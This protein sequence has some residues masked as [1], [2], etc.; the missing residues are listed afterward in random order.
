M[1]DH[2]KKSGIAVIL[3][4]GVLFVALLFFVYFIYKE[5]A[6]ASKLNEQINELQ[7]Q[8]E[9]VSEEN[10]TLE[11]E[12]E[13]LKVENKKLSDLLATYE[14]NPNETV[15]ESVNETID[16]SENETDQETIDESSE[17]TVVETDVES[18]D[19]HEETLSDNDENHKSSFKNLPYSYRANKIKIAARNSD[20]S[21][22][23]LA[24][25]TFD[26]GPN[27]VITPKIL[28]TLKEKGVHATFF[29]PGININS[30]TGQV[31]KRIVEEGNSVGT[32][33]FS[34]DYNLLYPGRKAN[35]EQILKEH[36]QTVAAM[37]EYL[38]D[39]FD[40]ALFRHPGGHMS[41]NSESLIVSDA[42]LDE[43]NV[44][45][46][47]WNTMTGDA[48][49]LH[50]TRPE[51]VPRPK[52]T[53]DVIN[54]FDMSKRYTP[55]SDVAVVL[56]HDASDKEVTAQALGAL[57]DHMKEQGYEFGVLY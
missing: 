6:G 51:D 41:W 40:T 38:G 9:K 1:E 53:Q 28:D 27:T 5:Y 49:S 7:S 10:E 19:T 42:A 20:Y 2:K 3:L 46:I 11:K 33:S 47:D 44:D 26:D 36:K 34:H 43:I 52:T 23:K 14:E 4:K 57:I 45:W 48:Q 8:I 17:E 56:M 37:K 39:N 31:L 29:I 30:T 18:N 50:L 25:L 21:G 12:V 32:H 54:N 35:A 24:F 55:N 16:E 13:E 22:K 15:D